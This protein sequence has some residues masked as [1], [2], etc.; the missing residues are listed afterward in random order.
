MLVLMRH[1]ANMMMQW[2]S[3]LVR[4]VQGPSLLVP[5]HYST[6]S[7][8]GAWNVRELWLYE[9]SEPFASC[10]KLYRSE[11]KENT[12]WQQIKHHYWISRRRRSS[13]SVSCPHKV[14]FHSLWWSGLLQR[15]VPRSC[16]WLMLYCFCCFGHQTFPL[17]WTAMRAE[18]HT[19]ET[20]IIN[21]FYAFCLPWKQTGVMCTTFLTKWRHSPVQPHLLMGGLG[22]CEAV[23]SG[24][25]QRARNHLSEI[26]I[27]QPST[28]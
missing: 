11:G 1:D 27:H 20:L 6:H 26:I 5:L 8:W 21:T 7:Q 22:R 2:W 23:C 17:G 24:K 9:L 14:S 28:A 19:M 18:I 3:D 25:R 15:H 13:L 4:C 16:I 12:K 10:L